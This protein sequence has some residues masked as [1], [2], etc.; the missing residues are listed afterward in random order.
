MNKNQTFVKEEPRAAGRLAGAKAEREGFEQRDADT[1]LPQHETATAALEHS[2][3]QRKR[4][5]QAAREL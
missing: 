3:G 1:S 5:P 2:K 4:R